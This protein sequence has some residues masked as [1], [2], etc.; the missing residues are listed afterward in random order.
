[1]VVISVPKP[2][3]SAMKPN[4]PVNTL[5]RNQLQ[6]LQ[7]AEF[8]LPVKL[9]TN[10]YINAI[11]TEG[12]AAK[13]IQRVTEALHQAHGVEPSGHAAGIAIAPKRRAVRGPDIAAVAETASKKS[14]SMSKAKSKKTKKAKGKRK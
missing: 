13:Y 12:E 5:L 2:P 8:R 9:Q 10:I 14:K 7:E 4:R 3:K 6:H 1:M 11:K